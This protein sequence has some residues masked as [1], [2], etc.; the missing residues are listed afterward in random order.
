MKLREGL[1]PGLSLLL[2]S[3]LCAFGWL[4]P[5][6]FPR[7]GANPISLPL[8]QAILFSV[9][10][11]MTT[12]IAMVQRLE[13][14]RGHHA[15]VCASFGVGFFVIPTSAAAFARNSVSDFEAVAVVC[16]TPIF[17][18]VLEPYLQDSPPRKGKAALAG[19]LV[20]IAGILSLVPLEAPSSFRA[21]VA[22]FVLLLTACELAATNCIAV[23][24]AV[25]TPG[26]STL[27]MAAQAGGATAISFAVIAVITRGTAWPS[28]ALKV[29]FLKVFLVDIPSLFLLFWLMSRLAASRMTA[30]FLLAPMFAAFAGLALEQTLPPP[31]AIVGLLLLAV[32]SGWLVFAP[33]ESEDE[34]LISLKAATVESSAQLP[35]KS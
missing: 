24:I 6:L 26:R 3:M 1:Y 14:P 2:L 33:G 35:R 29:Y 32:G 5:D 31:R 13:F 25:N 22:L 23:R 18:V 7:T 20:A 4:L 8:G 27:P 17:A 9:F 19:A 34:E 21:G 12:S 15:W 28:T 30:R 16:L 10:A 11:A